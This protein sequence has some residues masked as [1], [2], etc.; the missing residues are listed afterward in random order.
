M[1]MREL[2]RSGLQVSPLAFGCNVFGWTIDEATTWF[3]VSLATAAD[4][5]AHAAQAERQGDRFERQSEDFFARV[6][7]GYARRWAAAPQCIVRIDADGSRDDV[8]RRSRTAMQACGW[9]PAQT[10]AGGR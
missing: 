10:D 7:D 9:W 8:Q 6:V 4:R 3:D 5:H 1:T 2:G